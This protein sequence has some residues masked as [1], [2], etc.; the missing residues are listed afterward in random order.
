MRISGLLVVIHGH[1]MRN[2]GVCVLV[3]KTS[4]SYARLTSR[5]SAVQ[6]HLEP[7]TTIKVHVN[8]NQDKLIRDIGF[9]VSDADETLSL[10]R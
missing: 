9:G 5:I 8:I 6:T 1:T 10:S 7:L 2:H 3:V 4:L